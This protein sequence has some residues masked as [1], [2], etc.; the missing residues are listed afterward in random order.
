MICLTSKYF[1]K[2]TTVHYLYNSSVKYIFNYL[3]SYTVI[4]IL[5]NV[6]T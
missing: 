1:L 5:V 2:K 4:I 3:A 6:V